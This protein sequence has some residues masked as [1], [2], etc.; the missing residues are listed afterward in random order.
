MCMQHNQSLIGGNESYDT[1]GNK[2]IFLC[3]IARATI[4]SH[5]SKQSVG[6]LLYVHV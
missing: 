1:I 5:H 6:V 2:M 4:S 3:I